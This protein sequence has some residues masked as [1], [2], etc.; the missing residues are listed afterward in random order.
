MRRVEIGVWRG[1]GCRVPACFPANMAKR[2]PDLIRVPSSLFSAGAGFQRCFGDT[3]EV[4]VFVAGLGPVS[5]HRTF[6]LSMC[7]LSSAVPVQPVQHF[8]GSCFTR[9]PWLLLP[10]RFYQ[11]GRR[12]GRALPVCIRAFQ[13]RLF[14]GCTCRIDSANKERVRAGT[15][16]PFPFP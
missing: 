6:L 8:P 11:Q 9:G 7:P 4:L 3:T 5:F 15:F 13:A 16:L 12:G 2:K 10:D 14:A 1:A